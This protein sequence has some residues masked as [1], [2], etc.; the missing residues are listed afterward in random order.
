M[1]IEFH[2]KWT[3]FS[4]F[5]L[6]LWNIHP[7]FFPLL[8]YAYLKII[9]IPSSDHHRLCCC[10]LFNFS[11]ELFSMTI[12]N[13]ILWLHFC[14]SYTYNI[15]FPCSLC[16]L[17][18]IGFI[19]IKK[20]GV[21]W[22]TIRMYVR[23]CCGSA[24]LYTHLIYDIW[25]SH[26]KMHTSFSVVFFFHWMFIWVCWAAHFGVANVIIIDK[27]PQK[28]YENSAFGMRFEMINS[29]R[30]IRGI[31]SGFRKKPVECK[32]VVLYISTFISTFNWGWKMNS[33]IVWPANL[34]N[35]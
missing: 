9:R 1:C 34:T 3:L 31:R 24:L 23:M 21:F 26:S 14:K 27:S 30:L 25:P 19:K 12:Y 22:F 13:N 33:Q 17:V 28:C 6:D 32:I 8:Q 2:W 18:P 10:C 11:E 4:R 7:N 15:I 35:W 20:A 16:S 5:S 29:W